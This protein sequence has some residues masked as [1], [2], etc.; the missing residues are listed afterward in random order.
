MITAGVWTIS[1]SNVFL[2]A[3][4]ISVAIFAGTT[5][6]ATCVLDLPLVDPI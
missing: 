2:P 5:T 4:G 6:L 1:V 3:N